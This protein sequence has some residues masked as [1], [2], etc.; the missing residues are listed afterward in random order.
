MRSPRKLPLSLRSAD[1]FYA[2]ILK[3]AS[4]IAELF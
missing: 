3:K 4:L 2:D 1:L